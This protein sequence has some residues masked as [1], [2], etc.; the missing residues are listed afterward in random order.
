VNLLRVGCCGKARAALRANVRGSA[1]PVTRP[2]NVGPHDHPRL[3]NVR[4]E[5]LRIR[6]ATTGRTYVFTPSEPVQTI[7]PADA[8]ILLRSGHFR[9]VR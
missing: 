8:D 9:P 6:G 5:S 7:H 4:R 2:P 1:A 3:E